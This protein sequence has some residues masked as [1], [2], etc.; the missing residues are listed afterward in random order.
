MALTEMQHRLA[1]SRHFRRAICQE[2]AKGEGRGLF[3][4]G[5]KR[6]MLR[7]WTNIFSSW[8]EAQIKQY[9]FMFLGAD[10][11]TPEL[12]QEILYILAAAETALTS[13][14]RQQ[15]NKVLYDTEDSR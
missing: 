13:E 10:D 9:M 15:L 8:S 4:K 6:V 2:I 3:D 7:T 1:Y 12:R 14:Q 11:L 5:M